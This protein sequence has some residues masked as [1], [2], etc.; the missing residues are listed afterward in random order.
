MKK[1]FTIALAALALIAVTPQA[2]AGYDSDTLTLSTNACPGGTNQ[3]LYAKIPCGGQKDVAVQIEF[4]MSGAGTADQTFAF[5]RSVTGSTNDVE[6]LPSRWTL[7]GIPATGTTRVS[8]N[9]NILTHGV[10]TIYLM[11]S[12][13]A[14]ASGGVYQTNLIVRKAE[15]TMAP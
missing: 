6:T 9:T 14:A 12:T 13:N 10:G 15:K 3:W 4:N 8:L 11:Y 5:A 7:V 1:I 2:K